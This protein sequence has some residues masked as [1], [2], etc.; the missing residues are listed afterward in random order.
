MFSVFL[1]TCGNYKWYLKQTL[2]FAANPGDQI[3]AIEWDPEHAY[4]LHIV[5]RKGEYLQYTWT[6]TTNSSSCCRPEDEEALAA[7]IDGGESGHN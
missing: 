5:N 4:K 7:V 1:Y 6:W 3:A 2:K